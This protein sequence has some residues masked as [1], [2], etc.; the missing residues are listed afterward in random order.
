MDSS[1][2]TIS[3]FNI[4]Y[5]NIQYNACVKIYVD[6][7]IYIGLEND[8]T[9]VLHCV[10][11]TPKQILA[12]TTLAGFTVDS[13]KFYNVLVTGMKHSTSNSKSEIKST[14]I[15]SV[16]DGNFHIEITWM[17]PFSIEKKFIISLADA[18]ISD[19][20]RMIKINTEFNNNKKML[21]NYILDREEKS[22]HPNIAVYVDSDPR[23][24]EQTTFTFTFNKKHTASVLLIHGN[25]SVM[26]VNSGSMVQ[27]WSFGSSD[28]KTV[29]NG[30]TE[31]Y[32][33]QNSG[34]SSCP[35]T[36]PCMALITGHETTGPQQLSL[37]WKFSHIMPFLEIN[38]CGS[39]SI[40]R[41][42]EILFLANCGDISIPQITCNK[43]VKYVFDQSSATP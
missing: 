42:E 18:N 5:Q 6:G 19:L 33:P 8:M 41:V 26:G 9:K 22:G 30:Q 16:D 11:L 32:V 36:I 24:Y 1:V 10:T 37:S 35:R 29:V 23:K 7:D 13:H 43:P 31:N 38:P 21:D 15:Q 12:L 4:T 20:D 40:I 39:V 3:N 34:Y 2:T 28:K 27:I 25:L 14:F 17:I